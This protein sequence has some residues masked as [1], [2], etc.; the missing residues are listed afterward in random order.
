MLGSDALKQIV[1]LPFH[2][3]NT[4]LPLRLKITPSNSFNDASIVQVQVDGHSPAD[5]GFSKLDLIGSACSS[6]HKPTPFCVTL[7]TTSSCS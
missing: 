3:D 7:F 5:V 1:V 6:L 2:L 4:W